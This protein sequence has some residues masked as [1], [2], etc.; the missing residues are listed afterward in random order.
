MTRLYC[1]TI[2]SDYLE[3]IH[4]KH[5]FITLKVITDNNSTIEEIDLTKAQ[6]K[7]LM[8]DLQKFIDIPEKVACWVNI[9]NTGIGASTWGT[10]EEALLVA[11]KSEDIWIRTVELK[12]E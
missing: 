10:K 5:K 8:E 12:E 4:N 6:V 1:D 11:A 2:P 9:Y 3:L 7:L